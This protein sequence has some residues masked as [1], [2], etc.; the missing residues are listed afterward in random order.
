P[1]TDTT[2]PV[3]TINGNNPAEIE[4]G[5]TYSDLGA[6]VTDN[7]NDNL[8]ITT[9][10]DGVQTSNISLNTASS[11][12]YTISY[13]ATDQAGNTATSTRQVVVSEPVV[14]EVVPDEEPIEVTEPEEDTATST[15][16]G[17]ATTTPETVEDDTSTSTPET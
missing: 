9:Y 16:S 14:V 5:A 17:Q 11:T 15:S 6:T 3:I 10:V 12:T 4:V 8:G 1:G 7:V 2:P 13:T